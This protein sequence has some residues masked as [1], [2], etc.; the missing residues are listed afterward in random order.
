MDRTPRDGWQ[1]LLQNYGGNTNANVVRQ[2]ISLIHLRQEEGESVR[3]YANRMKAIRD[4][5][6]TTRLSK[7]DDYLYAILFLLFLHKKYETISLILRQQ[8]DLTFDQA[9]HRIQE[10]ET[11]LLSVPPESPGGAFYTGS[12]SQKN[13]TAQ[14]PRAKCTYCQ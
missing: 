6:S 13:Q 10:E 7:L 1:D 3:Q 14:K 9:V 12:H 5:L 8:D 11:R 4:S 2:I